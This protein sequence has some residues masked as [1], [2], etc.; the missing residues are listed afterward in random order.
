MAAIR[1]R[2]CRLTRRALLLVAVGRS[3][4]DDGLVHPGTGLGPGSPAAAEPPV[5]CS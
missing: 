2:L 1:A 5:P 4:R 3:R